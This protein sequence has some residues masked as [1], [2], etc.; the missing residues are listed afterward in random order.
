MFNANWFEPNRSEHGFYVKKLA[1]NENAFASPESLWPR[2]R[3]E[4]LI[5]NTRRM[6]F[7]DYEW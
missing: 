4:D 1:V 6:L 3:P 5:L 2:R 7:V